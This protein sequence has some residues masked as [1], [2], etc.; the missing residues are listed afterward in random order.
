MPAPDSHLVLTGPQRS[1][2]LQGHPNT[3]PPPPHPPTPPS[4][5]ARRHLRVLRP[6][7]PTALR[8]DAPRGP[9]VPPWAGGPPAE[10][11]VHGR[12]ARHDVLRPESIL[13]LCVPRRGG[14]AHEPPRGL[15]RPVRELEGRVYRPPAMGVSSVNPPR[16]LFASLISSCQADL[17]PALAP[18][19]TASHLPQTN[20]HVR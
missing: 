18:R 16:L 1:S 7:Q 5:R 10:V 2:T 9:P 6:S 12:L 17:A 19:K 3:I 14:A 13:R 15:A 20:L 4:L 11:V 8:P